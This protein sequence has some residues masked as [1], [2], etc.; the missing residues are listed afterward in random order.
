MKK[1]SYNYTYETTTKSLHIYMY[2]V[3]S[4][5]SCGLLLTSL[6]AWYTTKKTFLLE[7]I[8]FNKFFLFTIIITQLIVVFILSNMVNKLTANIT[9]TLF[10]IYCILTGLSIS[11]IF[12]IYTYSSIATT[13]I[14]TSIMFSTMS[15][16]GHTTKQDLTKIGNISLMLLIGIII[17]TIVNIWLQNNL[18]M[19]CISYIG[20]ISFSILIAWDTQKLKEIG[21]NISIEH[22]EQ[23]RRYSILGALILYLD[24]INLYLLILKLIGTKINKEEEK[25][26]K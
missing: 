16:W 13:F 7:M 18:F 11:S 24:F 17:S 23:L 26:K 10:I 2:N 21:N 19:L 6:I 22:N 25:E 20:I 4:W 3:Y 14:S 9:T 15:I 8:F 12:L 1:Y 5:M